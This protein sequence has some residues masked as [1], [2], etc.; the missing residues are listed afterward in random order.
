MIYFYLVSVIVY[1]YFIFKYRHNILSPFVFFWLFS[2]IYT[3]FPWLYLNSEVEIFLFSGAELNLKSANLILFLQSLS[4]FALC[5][6][7]PLPISTNL[8]SMI[9]DKESIIK[10]NIKNIYWFIYPI[11]LILVWYFPWGEWG[12][13]M[14]LGNSLAAASKNL[15]LITFCIYCNKSSAV[16]KFLAFVSFL[17]LCIIDTSRTALFILM[18]LYAYYSDLSWKRF[19]KYLYLVLPLFFLFVWITLKRNNIDFESKYILWVF[20]TESLLGGYSTFQSISIVENN[21]APFYSFLYPI[22]DMFIY[23]V[24]SAFF[25]IFG[26][27]KSNSFLTPNYFKSLYEIGQLSEV[28]APMGGHF[29]LAEFFLYFRFFSPLFVFFYYF[30]FFTIL[31]K[32]RYKEIA[33]IFYCSSFLL[34]K[35]S[36]FNNFKFL[37]AIFVLAYLLLLFFKIIKIITKTHLH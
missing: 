29:Y 4:N 25:D 7:I 35:A 27:I 15:L 32:I 34:V 11:S 33:L 17:F 14:S 18:F 5:F 23:I 26:F 3:F 8:I 12:V 9:K 37:I 22:V 10:F 19:F 28:Y 6:M 31:K 2:F 20:Y 24:P 13:E 30:L 36:I 21:L 16:K 1:F